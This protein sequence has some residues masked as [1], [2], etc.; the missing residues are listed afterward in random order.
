MDLHLTFSANIRSSD[1][2]LTFK[3]KTFVPP[4]E[5]FPLKLLSLLSSGTVSPLHVISFF[6]LEQNQVGWTSHLL[7]ILCY[8]LR[9]Y[10]DVFSHVDQMS[11]RVPNRK[12]QNKTRCLC[13]S[14]AILCF[15]SNSSAHIKTV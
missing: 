8:S 6:Y 4:M 10:E 7:R 11:L 5:V 3:T 14:A 1:L 15:I 13:H 9:P 12:E 2:N